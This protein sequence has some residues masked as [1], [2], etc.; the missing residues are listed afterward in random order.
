[1]VDVK[2]SVSFGSD[3]PGK[4][5]SGW[6]SIFGKKCRVDPMVRAVAVLEEA[7]REGRKL[8][9]EDG[10]AMTTVTLPVPGKPGVTL[11]FTEEHARVLLAGLLAHEENSDAH[12]TLVNL[13]REA[14]QKREP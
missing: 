4:E 13:L 2:Q 10:D 11:S 9:Q 12:K 8:L 14:L 1:V 3:A 6:V 7:L 5:Q